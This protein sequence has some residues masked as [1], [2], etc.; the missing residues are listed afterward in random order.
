MSH[1]LQ[2]TVADEVADELER[3]GRVSGQPASRI[4]ARLI[5]VA[6]AGNPIPSRNGSPQ[7]DDTG[8]RHVAPIQT[9]WLEPADPIERRLWRSDMWA[10]VVALH[11]RYPVE[12]GDLDALWWQRAARV[13]QLAAL[14]AWRLQIDRGCR[15]PR[16][17][18]R[19]HAQL[20]DFQRVLE[21]TPGVEAGSFRPNAPP[22]EWLDPVEP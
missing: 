11:T 7:S 12:M 2:V 10:A 17:E 3:R 13:E 22:F 18:L 8:G 6:L 21:Q 1:R 9:S 16:E 15:D 14:G 4:A 5:D 19:F 20:A